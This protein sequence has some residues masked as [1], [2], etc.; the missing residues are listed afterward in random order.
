MT[1]L[2]LLCVKSSCF[3]VSTTV[4]HLH[5]PIDEHRGTGACSNHLWLFFFCFLSPVSRD[6]T[7]TKRTGPKTFNIHNVPCVH[8]C[9]TL[10]F[11]RP[12]CLCPV[13]VLTLPPPAPPRPGCTSRWN[14][15]GPQTRPSSSWAERTGRTRY[16]CVC[17]HCVDVSA[18]ADVVRRRLDDLVPGTRPCF[19]GRY[20]GPLSELS[21]HTC[22][23]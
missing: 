13:P 14:S 16:Q 11:S 4:C 3:F 15:L 9:M 12:I 17:I 20:T 7:Y 19:S 22:G 21:A 5:T 2:R 6:A 10:S 8:A 18:T 23:A 1:S